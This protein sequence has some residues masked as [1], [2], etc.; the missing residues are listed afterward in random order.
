MVGVYCKTMEIY[1]Y[2]KYPN[3]SAGM[4]TAMIANTLEYYKVIPLYYSP[5][6]TKVSSMHKNV[7]SSYK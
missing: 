1:R 2:L 5:N 3:L 7:M 6:I 4:L